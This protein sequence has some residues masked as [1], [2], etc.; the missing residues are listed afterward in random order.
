[1]TRLATL[2]AI[3][4]ASIC[5]AAPVASAASTADEPF[6][7]WLVAA[8][9]PPLPELEVTSVERCAELGAEPDL[10]CSDMETF[11]ATSELGG[12]GTFL[13]EEG[14]VF[15]RDYVYGNTGA[16]ERIATL[17]GHP[18]LL[19]R[20]YDTDG[21]LDEA[22]ADSFARCGI[23]HIGHHPIL[24]RWSGYSV[25]SIEISGARLLSLCTYIRSL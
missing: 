3:L 11:I 13:H 2:L 12:P 4:T 5:V 15:A 10:G 1:M 18:R 17:I 8:Q 7:G 24:A 23:E 19:W 14:H 16:E 21:S 20:V 6:A 22:F 9:M 25:G